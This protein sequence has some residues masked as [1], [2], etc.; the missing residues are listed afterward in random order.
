MHQSTTNDNTLLRLLAGGDQ[1]AY[2]IIFERYW[3]PVYSTALLLTKSPAMAEDVAQD[4]FTMVWEKRASMAAV[5]KLEG[6]LFVAARNTIYTRLRKLASGKA[7]RDYL[8]H[9]FN[10]NGVQTA[11]QQ[12]EFREMEKKVLQAIRQL[13][14]QQQKAFQLSRFEGMRHED[15]AATMGVS[16]ITI[17]SYIVQA[18][19]T[20]RKALANYPSGA[21]ITLWA[22]SFIG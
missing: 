1:H 12:A 9:C 16:R 22:L 11:A 21:L 6:F 7:Y 3:D 20:L 17:K 15:I 8:L 13:P 18:I 4:V 5:E 2:R 10:E 19:A 14:P